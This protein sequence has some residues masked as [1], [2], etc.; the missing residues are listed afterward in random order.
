MQM[1][2]CRNIYIDAYIICFRE[3]LIGALIKHAKKKII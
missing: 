3:M 1:I 2:V